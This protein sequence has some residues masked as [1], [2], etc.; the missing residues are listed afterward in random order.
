MSLTDASAPTCA[1]ASG[2]DL[3]ANGT[4]DFLKALLAHT[5]GNAYIC[6]FTNERELGAERHIHTRNFGDVAGFMDKWDRTGRGMFVC[7]STQKDGT[8][9]RNKENCKETNAAHCDIDFKGV[10]LLGEEDARGFVLKQLARL[11]YQPSAIIF[12]GN[13]VHL[14]YFFKEPIDTQEHMA[15]IE[16]LYGQLADV[17]AGDPAVC[18]VARVMRLPGTHNTKNGEN[19]PVEIIELHPDRRY[20]LEE[21]EEWLSEQSPVMLRKSREFAVPAGVSAAN[22]FDFFE[23]YGKKHGLKPPIDVQ[24]RLEQMIYMG[25]GESSIHQTQLQC[26]AAML[27]QGV[28]KDDVV[29]TIMAYT[30]RAAGDYGKRWNWRIEERNTVKMCDDWIKKHPPEKKKVERVERNAVELKAITGGA[31]KIEVEQRAIGTDASGTSN[32]IKMPVTTPVPPKRA[33]LH[34]AVGK[35]VIA[36]FESEGE[37][38]INND[39]GSWF[40]S[41]GVWELRTGAKWLD[42]RIEHNFKQ[43]GYKTGTKLINETRNWILRQPELWREGELPWDQHGKIP[44]RS[45]LVDPR[46]GELEIAR[47]DHYC[48]WRVEVQYDPEAKCPWWETMIADMFGDRDSVEQ[49]AL[50]GV[51]QELMGAAL[52]DKKARGLRKACVFWGNENRAKSGVLDV[53]AGLFGDRLITAALGTVDGTHGLMPFVRRAPWVLHEAFGP[54]WHMSATVKA[55]VTGE[56]VQINIKNGPLITQTIRSPIFWATNF[57]PQFKEATRAI[58]ERMIVIEVTRKFDVA[59]PIGT[60][61]EAIRRGFDKPGEFIIATELP[62]VL[63]WAVAGL[64]R[65]L[66][67]GSIASTESIAETA[68]AIHQDSNLVAGFLEDCVEFDPM[69]RIKVTDFCL[70]HSAW[71]ME[72]KG[73]DRRL[74]TNEAIGKALRAIGDARVCTDRGDMRD[75]TGRYYGGIALNR[76]GLQFHKRAFES[77][78]FEGKVGN[79]TDPGRE[80]NSLIPPSW[81]ARESVTKM[82]KHHADRVTNDQND[83]VDEVPG[84]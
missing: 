59:K 32:V 56:P 49:R 21:L 57:P 50:V 58:V 83:D 73:E 6:S 82:R 37:E 17:V 27:N 11:K 3:K 66:E 79:A 43:L 44:T 30:H 36:H 61:A 24:Q 29:A 60:A 81:D 33:E 10:D 35:A 28:P 16:A 70:A 51:V 25:S 54:Q 40:Y 46:T 47:P 68:K 62:G 52:I 48:T 75:A 13:G 42:V 9:K 63:S 77:R 84:Q 8:E 72:L 2:T 45:G 78:L 76:A 67:R 14:Y 55:I 38:L 20:D 65:A 23:E 26:T 22:D 34:I 1:Q 39:D 15:R 74:P 80:V 69:A 53:T 7:V 19:T 41:G 71:W 64:R 18:E 31:G 4:V 5:S 12:S